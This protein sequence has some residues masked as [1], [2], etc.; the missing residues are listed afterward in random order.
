M[1]TSR[2]RIGGRTY[3]LHSLNT[4]V[5]GSGAAGLNAAVR[6]H[7]HGQA[8]VAVVTSR[9]GAGASAESGSDKQTYYKLSL[10][11]D[12]PDSAAEMAR[13]LAAGGSAHGDIAL[14]EAQGSL[15]AFFHLVALG[16]PF[17]H[18][19]FG[20]YVGYKTDHDPR[21]RATSAGP[22][23][24]RMMFEKLLAECRRRRVR[25]F[26]GH[27]AI[28]LLAGGRGVRRR[29][30]GAVALDRAGLG[31]RERGFILFNAVN[32]IAATGGPGGLYEHSVYPESQT[33]SHGLLF[34]AGA[35]A[36]NLTE[37]QFGLASTKF[38]WNVSGAYQQAVPRYVSTDA[39][40]G[41][42]REFLND[43]F[44]DMGALAT[45]VFLKGYQWPFDPRKARGGGS[46]LI[47]VLVHEETV[48]KGR[49][50]FLDFRADPRGDGRLAPFAP[51]LLGP[52]A[53]AYLERS[54][55]LMATPI[56]RLRKMNP[57]AVALY[58]AHGI[59]LAREPL[60]IAVCAQHNNGGFRAS[61]WWESNV[62]GL[63][64]VGE[65]CG[66]HGV[67][68]PGGSALNAGQ[69]G[70]ARAALFI[71]RRRAG[72]PLSDAAFA[73]AAGPLVRAR[74]ELAEA[75]LGREQAG[76][77][78]PAACLAEV[79]R[80]MSACGAV[81]R[82]AAAVRAGKDAARGLWL[83]ARRGLRAA[84]PRDLPRAFKSLD[85]ALTH[86]VYL[87]AIAEYLDRGGKSRGSYLVPDPAG[88]P[89][90][91][92]LGGRWAFSLA[93][94][95][96]FV[97]RNILEVRLGG[98]GRPEKRWVP[99]RPVPPAEAWFETVWD[100]FRN[101]RIVAEEE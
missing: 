4:L 47:D 90:H 11:G 99:V 63:F 17:P 29:V 34:E 52:E 26:D 83:R 65:V 62:R 14:A 98:R 40:G 76:S 28:A 64:P 68:R 19:R 57:P 12:R 58:R 16:V 66:T 95:D 15:E 81:V 7:E 3:P 13:D 32:V 38:R 6:L 55:A 85:L 84:S 96:D 92:R 39:R 88:E 24:S 33:G 87:E 49:R 54:G 69:V 74:R 2:V 71:A 100:D 94:P 43:Y 30:L 91:P 35:T 18:D 89:P 8:D 82:D 22:L 77:L 59:D 44:P 70:G 20:A 45:A 25:V 31:S 9:L 5:I 78:D 10:S 1:R 21:Q 72:R 61:V 97:G 79:R 27:E 37:S 93:G 51:A 60:E 101:D 53:F 23:T 75:M 67:T 50:V 73:R 86:A 42:E 46:S 41:D 80:R 56:A 36:H 48:V